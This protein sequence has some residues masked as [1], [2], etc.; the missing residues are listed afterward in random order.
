MWLKHNVDRPAA[1]G[2]MRGHRKDRS[3]QGGENSDGSESGF[4]P[5]SPFIEV[6]GSGVG[7]EHD[8]GKQ[9]WLAE[10]VGD[11]LEGEPPGGSGPEN[12]VVFDP[13]GAEREPLELRVDH[14]RRVYVAFLHGAN[15]PLDRRMTPDPGQDDE[16]CGGDDAGARRQLQRPDETGRDHG[17]TTFLKSQPN[18]RLAIASERARFRHWPST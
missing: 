2:I 12:K 13:G 4:I 10:P 11:V 9:L 1:A 8:L 6:R 7:S 18:V 17:S 3:S 14:R 16:P 15:V 5:F